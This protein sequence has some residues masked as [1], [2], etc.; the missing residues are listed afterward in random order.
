MD[1]QLRAEITEAILRNAV[2]DAHKREMDALF[3]EKA[4]QEYTPSKAHQAQM[5]ALFARDRRKN[6]FVKIY[7]VTRRIA[8]IMLIT[9]T[10]LFGVL[11][12]DYRVQATIRETIIGWYDRFTLFRFQQANGFETGEREWFPEFL[13]D[14]F[15][16]SELIELHI[17]RYI[18]LE[19]DDGYY[20]L[21]EYSP[22]AD[23]TIA[24]DNEFTTMKTVLLGGIEYFVLTPLPDSEHYAQVIWQMDGY[25]F[26]LLSNFSPDILLQI[27]LSVGFAN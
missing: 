9:A 10:I 27:A 14:G 17:G 20:I 26:A 21:F 7:S 6:M 12:T 13:P 8:V 11:L 4:A 3:S 23:T 2:K 22:A 24:V 1:S 5:R 16:I 15:E 19:H 18:F 25:A